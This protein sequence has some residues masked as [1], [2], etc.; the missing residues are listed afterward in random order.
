MQYQ[1]L[2]LDQLNFSS[3]PVR[4]Y[5]SREAMAQLTASLEATGGP[6]SPVIVRELGGSEYIVV[7][8]E[9]RVRALMALGR[10]PDH[11][12]PCLI[13]EF[14]DRNALEYA[15]VENYVRSPLTPYEEALTVR[16]L[17]ERY[18]LRQ[19]DLAARLGRSEQHLSRLFAI[20]SLCEELRLA[21]HSREISL[22]H[23][24][25]LLPLRNSPALQKQLLGEITTRSL[26]VKALRT[27]VRELLGEGGQWLIAPGEVWLTERAKVAIHPAAKGYTVDF[28]F[29]TAEEFERILKLLRDRMTGQAAGSAAGEL[30]AG[31]SPADETAGESAAGETKAAE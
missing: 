29:S 14:D 25:E 18:R 10:P 19:R 2:R 22:A 15:L 3:T 17:T 27:R 21:L 6:L 8:G 1:S 31:E 4:R 5:R 28:S 20:F 26:S 9:S 11:P 13:G 23:A 24:Q 30:P 12:V 7:A 16:T